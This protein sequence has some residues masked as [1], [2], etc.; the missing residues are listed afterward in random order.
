M[1]IV[2]DC[3]RVH[4]SG[5]QNSLRYM[6]RIKMAR[7]HSTSVQANKAKVMPGMTFAQKPTCKM[8]KASIIVSSAV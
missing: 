6:G 2:E 7:N 1:G 3:L 5:S 8:I 4:S